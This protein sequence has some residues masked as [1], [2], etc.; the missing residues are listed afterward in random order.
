[1]EI[2]FT[3]LLFAALLLLAGAGG[4]RGRA[5][6]QAPVAPGKGE[7][8]PVEAP[9]ECTRCGMDRA[10]F[11]RSR[12]RVTFADGSSV[13][14]CSLHCAAAELQARAGMGVASIQVGDYGREG[15]PLIDARTATWVIGGA[16]RGVMTP[17]AKWAF[18]SRADAE[19]FIARDGGQRATYEEALER[20]RQ[21]PPKKR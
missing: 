13:G 19:A 12:M 21:D 6:A 2:R 15:H 11:A 7:A 3:R 1:M 18:S 4:L 17:V 14:H 20:A 10:R 8:A 16:Q 5:A 9:A